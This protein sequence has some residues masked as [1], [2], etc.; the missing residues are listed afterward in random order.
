MQP[1][2]SKCENTIFKGE[3]GGWTTRNTF[4]CSSLVLLSALSTTFNTGTPI[5][6]LNRD[7]CRS[8]FSSTRWKIWT[9]TNKAYKSK[10][11]AVQNRERD[12]KITKKSKTKQNG[13]ERWKRRKTP[14][15]IKYDATSLRV[16]CYCYCV[17]CWTAKTST[18]KKKQKKN[19]SNTYK[20]I[21]IYIW[22]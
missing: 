12:K 6:T 22:I 20:Y 13:I 9:F 18:E 14:M 15:V 7:E 2:D 5:Y 16:H 17:V 21:S 11:K 3:L 1:I 4:T 19:W 8:E 10:W